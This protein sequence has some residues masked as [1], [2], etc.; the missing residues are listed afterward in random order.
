MF[1][2]FHIHGKWCSEMVRAAFLVTSYWSYGEML[3]GLDFA[4]ALQ[5]AGMRVYMIIPPSHRRIITGHAVPYSCLVPHSRNWN[6]IIFQSVFENFRPDVLILSDSLNFC[7]SDRHYGIQREDLSIFRCRLAGID[8]YEWELTRKGMDTYGYWSTIP[9]KVHLEELGPRIIPCPLGR[10]EELDGSCEYRYSLVRDIHVKT[11]EEVRKCRNELD[12]PEDRPIVFL[13]CAGWQTHGIEDRKVREYTDYCDQIF[14]ERIREMSNFAYVI[15]LGLKRGGQSMRR[16]GRILDSV[17]TKGFHQYAVAADLYLSR[18][19]T[20]TSM[21][22]T[23]FLG[24][25]CLCLVHERES[26]LSGF[27]GRS[28]LFDMYPVGWKHF[29]E[30]LLKKTFYGGMIARWDLFSEETT[31]QIMVLLADTDERRKI[32][33]STEKLREKLKTLSRPEKIILK[34]LGEKESCCD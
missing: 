22:R 21:I 18:N 31:E 30:P 13:S 20:S 32:I 7:F 24:T 15:G 27:T 5:K 4:E 14:L 3:I 33:T 8:I 28:Y 26:V 2:A 11:Q 23:A 17:P 29:L 19:M 16:F 12:L 6:R 9:E 25:P 10:A 1:P 34:I